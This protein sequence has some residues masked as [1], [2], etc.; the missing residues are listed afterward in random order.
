M[1]AEADGFA[2]DVADNVARPGYLG[3]AEAGI[4]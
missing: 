4:Y 1:T 2:D 3:G